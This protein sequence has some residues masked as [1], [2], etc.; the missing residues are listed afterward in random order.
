M[1]L[2]PN[3]LRQGVVCIGAGGIGS[4]ML[5]M[6]A[7][8]GVERFAIYD[9]DVVAD[10]NLQMQNF[11][12]DEIGQYKVYVMERRLRAI[13]PRVFVSSRA[14]RFTDFAVL[15][16]IVVCAVDSM[17]SRKEIFQAVRRRR[18][19]IALFVDGRLTRAGDFIALYFIDPK[20]G[21]EV[22]NYESLLYDDPGGA[23]P[24]RPD[25]MTAHVPLML[26]GL[27]GEV[28]AQWVAG[29]S[30]PWKVTYDGR[31]QHTERYYAQAFQQ[32]E[33]S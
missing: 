18:D 27:A 31:A 21:Q 3:R 12:A 10:V 30:H 23:Q 1:M 14:V 11:N 20:N 15:D 13:N 4:H 8:A 29:R 17:Q 33:A 7:R 2:Y 9:N 19:S 28:L 32:S 24:P 22:Q 16:G 5:P 26:T 6:L 25:C